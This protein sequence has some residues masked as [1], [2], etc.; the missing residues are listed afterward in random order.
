MGGKYTI[1][2]FSTHIAWKIW[3]ITT[4][5]TSNNSSKAIINQYFHN[6]QVQISTFC[7]TSHHISA[8]LTSDHVPSHPTTGIQNI[9]HS[10][11]AHIN[12]IDKNY[13]YLYNTHHFPAWY[14]SLIPKFI[15]HISLHPLCPSTQL[16]SR[17]PPWISPNHCWTQLDANQQCHPIQICCNRN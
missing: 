6:I 15:L 5:H 4:T 2:L 10:T 11:L 9:L 8:L 7:L 14:H 3:T 13:L 1:K 17:R 12:S 16:E